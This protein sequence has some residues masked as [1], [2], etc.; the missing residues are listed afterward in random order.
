[1]QKKMI[2]ECMRAVMKKGEHYG[3]VPGTNS[4][5]SLFKAGADTLGFMF[6][7]RAEYAID[8]AVNDPDYIYYRV[9]CMLTHIPT[10]QLVATGMGSCNSREQ[11]YRRATLRKCPKCNNEAIKRSKFPDRARPR[12]E[13]G[14]HCHD[15]V[16]GCGANFRYEDKTITEQTTGVADPSDLDNT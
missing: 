2:A 6:R 8:R 11:K 15:K 13:P 1:M 5:P 12:D 7:L 3:V 14:W 4:K 16:G 10:G 9:K